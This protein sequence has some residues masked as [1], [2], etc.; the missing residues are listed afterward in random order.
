MVEFT[1]FISPIVRRAAS[2]CGDVNVECPWDRLPILAY[3]TV[4]CQASVYNV[5]NVY[6]VYS[7]Y[8]VFS[9][10]NVYSGYVLLQYQRVV[11]CNLSDQVTTM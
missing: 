11:R 10:Y 3:Y 1:I 5:Y 8:N 4:Q 2:N 9:V 6:N 7:V